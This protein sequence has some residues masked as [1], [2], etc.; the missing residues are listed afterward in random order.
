MR[1]AGF[2]RAPVAGGATWTFFLGLAQG[3]NGGDGVRGWVDGVAV[4]DAWGGAAGSEVS[5]TVVL[6]GA[7]NSYYE[8]VVEY[9]AA[10]AAYGCTL[11]WQAS[12]WP[13]HVLSSDFTYAGSHIKN[14]P[15]LHYFPR[16]PA[17]K[18]HCFSVVDFC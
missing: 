2:V 7:S 1:W 12:G 17:C 6:S 15:L 18:M 9:K 4:V 5:G 13:K 14:S 16:K 3:G 10:G 8:V 11:S